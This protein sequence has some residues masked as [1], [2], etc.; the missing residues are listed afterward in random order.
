MRP[1]NYADILVFDPDQFR[2]NATYQNP[3]ACATGLDWCLINGKAAVRRGKLTGE[4]SGCFI[5]RR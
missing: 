4:K 3:T 2:D 5:R 1:G